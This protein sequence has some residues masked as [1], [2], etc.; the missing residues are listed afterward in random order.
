[1]QPEALGPVTV[2]DPSPPRLGGQASPVGLRI[3]PEGQELLRVLVVEGPQVGKAQEEFG[4]EGGIVGML[5][6]H[7]SPQ[8]PDEGLLKDFHGIHV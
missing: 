4:E 5:L 1:M 2:L 3:D 7:Q 6:R 8:G